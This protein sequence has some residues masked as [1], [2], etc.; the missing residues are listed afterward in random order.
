M[1]SGMRSEETELPS[2]AEKVVSPFASTRKFS[3]G[4]G[5]RSSAVEAETIRLSSMKHFANTYAVLRSR[6]KRPFA[7]SFAKRFGEPLERQSS[8]PQAK[9]AFGWLIRALYITI[10][11]RAHDSSRGS[12]RNLGQFR[13]IAIQ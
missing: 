9:C 5:N 10:R 7:G 1:I 2:R 4:F 8:T 12:Q 3:R 11:D 13:Q 6:L